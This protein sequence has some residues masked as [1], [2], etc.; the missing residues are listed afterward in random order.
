MS[1]YGVSYTPVEIYDTEFLNGDIDEYEPKE[2]VERKVK[3]DY[4]GRHCVRYKNELYRLHAG[5]TRIHLK[6]EFE[7]RKQYKKVFQGWNAEREVAH[8]WVHKSQKEA[9]ISGGRMYFNNFKSIWSYGTHFELARRLEIP[10]A[11]QPVILLNNNRY[12]QQ[13]NEQIYAVRGAIPDYWT[14]VEYDAYNLGMVEYG[15]NERY[16]DDYVRVL[17]GFRDEILDEI[18][19]AERKRRKYTLRGSIGRVKKFQKKALSFIDLFNC[20]SVVSDKLMESFTRDVFESYADFAHTARIAIRGTQRE[21]ERDRRERIQRRWNHRKA[22]ILSAKNHLELVRKYVAPEQQY[23]EYLEGEREEITEPPKTPYQFRNND[24][25]YEII[26][27][28]ELQRLDEQYED[29][30]EKYNRKVRAFKFLDK[31]DAYTPLEEQREQLINGIRG[32]LEFKPTIPYYWEQKP[33]E[34]KELTGRELPDD[35]DRDYDARRKIRREKKAFDYLET[36]KRIEDVGPL[37]LYRSGEIN[38]PSDLSQPSYW[39]NNPEEFYELTGEEFPNISLEA[40]D[41]DPSITRVRYNEK[42]DRVQTSKGARLSVDEVKKANLLYERYAEE[43]KEKSTGPHD[44]ISINGRV[45]LGSY[46][47]V[48]AVNSEGTFRFGCHKIVNSEREYI[49]NKLNL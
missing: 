16:G 49:I 4:D 36:F 9:E 25:R 37:E 2:I 44:F 20:K 5:P 43:A 45:E 46:T 3:E 15:T 14:V 34:F 47:S 40:F 42:H 23:Q 30:Y 41:I 17:E 27:G 19:D 8:L 28:E 35:C 21:Q 7:Y 13:T 32:S 38:R 1:F 29:E 18:D 33:D 11:E 10:S 6:E 24:K 31:Y 12:S 39:K 26:T 48:P 22:E